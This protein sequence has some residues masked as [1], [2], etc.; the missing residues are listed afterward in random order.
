MTPED[1]RLRLRDFIQRS[2]SRWNNSLAERIELDL[3]RRSS[4][5][6]YCDLP[7]CV[8]GSFACV[9]LL[10]RTDAKS[11]IQFQVLAPLVRDTHNYDERRRFKFGCPAPAIP[12][13]RT[14]VQFTML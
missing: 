12:H 8:A 14:T 3:E 4:Y 9:I 7:L 1:R 2:G 10:V 5:R 6:A 11:V 13:T